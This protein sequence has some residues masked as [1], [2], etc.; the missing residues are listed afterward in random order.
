MRWQQYKSFTLNIIINVILTKNIL[1][2]MPSIANFQIQI[3]FTFDFDVMRLIF[4]HFISNAMQITQWLWIGSVDVD[5]ELIVCHF[6]SFFAHHRQQSSVL[7][8]NDK[9]LNA[10]TQFY[11]SH[12]LVM[13]FLTFALRLL[14]RLNRRNFWRASCGIEKTGFYWEFLC[15][16]P[17]VSR[18]EMMFDSIRCMK[19]IR[20]QSSL[21]DFMCV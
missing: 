17:S 4:D 9:I 8:A 1:L 15:R 14:L 19:I 16:R 12:L 21:H 2:T 7:K 11:S 5:D 20:C 6:F 13:T 18:G 3:L 10:W